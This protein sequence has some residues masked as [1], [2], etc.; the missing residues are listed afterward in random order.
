[1]FNRGRGHGGCRETDL[2]LFIVRAGLQERSMLP[3]LQKNYE[4][5]K[6][7]NMVLLLNATD[8]EHRYGYRYGY[9]RYGY[10][11]H[12][13]YGYYGNNKKEK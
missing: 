1:M 5:K 3:E 4:E 2:T 7:N 6:Y 10:G 8:T 13:G 9:G 11:K 12:H